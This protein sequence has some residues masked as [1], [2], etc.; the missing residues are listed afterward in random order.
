MRLA[1]WLSAVAALATIG[2]GTFVILR[3]GRRDVWLRA[4]LAFGA[5]FLLAAAMLAMLPHAF[6]EI[7]GQA[8][9]FVLVGY[10]LIHIF[11]HTLVPH[12]HFG[13]ET[14]AA[15]AGLGR[16]S[17]LAATGGMIVHSI[18]DGVTIGSGFLLD[19]HLGWLLFLAIVLHKL[20]D[21]FTVASLALASGESNRAAFTAVGLL[22][23]ATLVG[24]L[25]MAAF[26]HWAGPALALS[27]GVAIYVAATDLMPEVN[28]EHSIRWSFIVFAG[29]LAFYVS[30]YLFNLVGHTH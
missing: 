2:G 1:F 5:G 4:F 22:G 17:F 20:P 19:P 12:F 9:L 6:D 29:V 7:G 11:E 24:T 18:F 21:G 16:G 26:E 27:A 13:E 25:G 10:L 14:H 30:E 3:F 15:E 23:I 8:A 28:R